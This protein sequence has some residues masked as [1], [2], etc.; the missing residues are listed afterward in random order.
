[1]PQ[2]ETDPACFTYLFRQGTHCHSDRY[3]GGHGA[4]QEGGWRYTFR[5]YAPGAES[6]ALRLF[7]AGEWE[8]VPLQGAQGLFTGAVETATAPQHWRYA[9]SL[10]RAGEKVELCDPYAFAMAQEGGAAEVSGEAP[11]CF[12]DAEWM[13]RRGQCCAAG[14]LCLYVLP[15]VA[16]LRSV[17]GA[18]I[19]WQA[20]GDWLI[21]Y[22][23][24]MGYT[25]VQLPQ[26][27]AAGAF[28]P[29]RRPGG[30]RELCRFVDRLHGAGIGV[31]LAW[32][33]PACHFAGDLGWTV[34]ET[35]AYAIASALYWMREFH[36]D[37]LCITQ[38]M[39]GAGE[40]ERRAFLRLLQEALA[41]ACPDALRIAQEGG[42]HPL[43]ATSL[44]EGGLGFHLA[45]HTADGA[46]APAR[47]LPACRE[48]E[49]C[50][51]PAGASLSLPGQ[52]R[53]PYP[54]AVR[55]VAWLLWMLAPGKKACRMGQEWGLEDSG[56]DGAPWLPSAFAEPGQLALREYM[57]ALQR[58]YLSHP[59]FWRQDG[60][61]TALPVTAE[62]CIALL[63][64]CAGEAP[65]WCV[66]NAGDTGAEVTLPV[67]EAGVWDVVFYSGP[68]GG[69]TY[70]A[71]LRSVPDAGGHPTV[72]VP[73]PPC[74]GLLL[75]RHTEA[76]T[77][78]VQG[79]EGM[80]YDAG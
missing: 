37:G 15:P 39:P 47:G 71:A 31:L 75:A 41:R 21:R 5:L 7:R 54:F 56:G 33:P 60:S 16:S 48:T 1:M 76:V 3:L 40:G 43:T 36:L 77:I 26:G 12:Q 55:R 34:E 25:H 68:C 67:E 64:Q 69:R 50:L 6:A 18:D 2:R 17:A 65:V 72:V 46:W 35:Q 10:C 45:W 13:E 4:R 61:R 80:P 9:F 42:A 62:G 8:E 63:C 14:P 59:V 11:W 22:M 51:C 27:V 44:L 58:L 32:A 29:D 20:I 70:P 79:E 23:R 78:V 66:C 24:Y 57:V 73:L 38:G 49:I 19:T 30:A 28:A 74:T 52:A 53:E